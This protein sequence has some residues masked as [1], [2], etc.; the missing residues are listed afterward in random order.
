MRLELASD[1][2]TKITWNFLRERIWIGS[3]YSAFTSPNLGVLT[4]SFKRIL[5]S[6]IHKFWDDFRNQLV[7]DADSS[8]FF[9]PLYSPYWTERVQDAKAKRERG[10][11]PTFENSLLKSAFYLYLGGL[12]IIIGI[13]LCKFIW[14]MLQT[15]IFYMIHYVYKCIGSL[16]ELS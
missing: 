2:R 4:E 16:H 5:E 1:L 10:R 14:W 3:Q 15:I 6:G 7:L 12:G 8:T 13:L 11:I 9:K